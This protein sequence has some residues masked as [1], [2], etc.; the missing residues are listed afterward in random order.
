MPRFRSG[1]W[2]APF[3][4]FES[5]TIVHVHLG[6]YGKFRQRESPPP[7]PVGQIRMRLV[8][9][10]ATVD[11]TG[12]TTCR[13]IDPS[14]RL[15]VVDRLGPDP[16]AGGKKSEVWK[17]ISERN[18]PIG[19][20][21]LDQAVVAGVG[22]IFRAEVLFETEL[23]PRIPEKSLSEESF[24]LFWKLLTRLMRV[25]LRHGLIIAVTAREAGLPLAKVP[26]NR[27]FRVHGRTELPSVWSNHLVHR[28]CRKAVIR[29]RIVPDSKTLDLEN[30]ALHLGQP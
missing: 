24:D 5:K 11:L 16:L 17:N 30:K 3:Y 7:K 13:V 26:D 19:A 18:Q 25:G 1:R 2:E 27:R 8:G 28:S 12:P 10:N 29:L 20:L 4:E 9:P 22:N 15:D 6:R 23:D 21:L 14:Q